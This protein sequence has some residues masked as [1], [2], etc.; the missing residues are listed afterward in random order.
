MVWLRLTFF[1]AAG[2]EK[3]RGIPN[4]AV[5][6]PATAAIWNLWDGTGFFALRSGFLIELAP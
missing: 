4:R 3:R 5:A 2:P 6:V 1:R